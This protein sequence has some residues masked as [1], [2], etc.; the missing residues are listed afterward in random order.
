MKQSRLDKF[1]S[2]QTEYTRS[3]IKVM[4]KKGEVAVDGVTAK[5]PGMKITAGKNIVTV[6]SKTIGFSEHTYV[7]LNKPAGYVSSTDEMT[8]EQLWSLCLRICGKKVCFPQEGLIRIR[9]ELCLSPMTE[10]WRIVCFHQAGIYRK[11]IL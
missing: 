8:A 5:D 9:W 3:Q 11:F 10:N 2:E 6:L 1:I 4:V 7:L